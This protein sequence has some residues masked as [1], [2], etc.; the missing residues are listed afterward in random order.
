MRNIKTLVKELKWEIFLLG[1]AKFR[2]TWFLGS[3]MIF[4]INIFFF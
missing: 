4:M 1:C 3:F 2:C